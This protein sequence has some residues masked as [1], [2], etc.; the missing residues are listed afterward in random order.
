MDQQVNHGDV[1]TISG[2]GVN[3]SGHTIR[4][5][6]NDNKPPPFWGLNLKTRKRGRAVRLQEY[7]AIEQGETPLDSRSIYYLDK[8]IKL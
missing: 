3:K 2:I 5:I 8:D 4:R 6:R 7:R 1:F